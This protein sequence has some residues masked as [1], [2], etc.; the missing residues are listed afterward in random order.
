MSANPSG[1]SVDA[2]Y[3][4]GTI[5]SRPA[6][7][8]RTGTPG[9]GSSGL[10]ALLVGGQDTDLAASRMTR[11]TAPGCDIITTC[12]ARISTVFTA[13]A[14]SAMNRWRSGG[15]VLSCVPITNHDG[16]LFHAAGPDGW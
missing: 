16:M 4:S 8:V 14:R 7:G 1:R 3:A 5:P 12:D 10:S 11:V 15:M 2:N 6:P 13:P 9:H